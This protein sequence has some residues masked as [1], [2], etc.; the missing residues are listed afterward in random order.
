MRRATVVPFLAVVGLSLGAARVAGQDASPQPA[1][2]G[3][4]VFESYCTP[5]HGPA[6]K[7]DGPA[8][9][10]LQPP[11]ANFTDSEWILGGDLASVKTTIENGAT[12]TAMPPWKS[13]LKPEEIEAVAKYVISLSPTAPAAAQQPANPSAPAKPPAAP[14]A[15]K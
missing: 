2:P 3:K 6:G 4:A 11:P 13:I 8:G 10:G 9:A 7:G 1:D 12:G 14:E 15:P 5:C